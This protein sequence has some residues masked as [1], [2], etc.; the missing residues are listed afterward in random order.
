[1]LAVLFFIVVASGC[2]GEKG[3]GFVGGW[4]GI[5]ENKPMTLD[6]KYEDGI[7]HIDEK[8]SAFGEEF[9]KRLEGKAESGTVL[10]IS[11][12]ILTMRLEGGKIFYKNRTFIKSK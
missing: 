3:L 4:T 10:S 7:F 8:F 6:I 11:G 9:Y 5:D 2:N 1:M 12:G